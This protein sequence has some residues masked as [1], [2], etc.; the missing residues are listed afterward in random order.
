MTL[1]KYVRIR[2]E[3]GRQM[4]TKKGYS[5]VLA[6]LADAPGQYRKIGER[7]RALRE[8]LKRAAA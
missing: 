3:E 2:A 1:G 8:L 5:A 6:K 7:L 4:F